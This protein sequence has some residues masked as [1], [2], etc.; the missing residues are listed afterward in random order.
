VADTTRRRQRAQRAWRIRQA[1]QALGPERVRAAAETGARFKDT[2]LLHATE[3]RGIQ[4]EAWN[5]LAEQP[6]PVVAQIAGY[7]R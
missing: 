3:A 1:I 4:R 5:T 6:A 7:G 2:A